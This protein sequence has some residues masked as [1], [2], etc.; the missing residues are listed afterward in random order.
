MR[1]VPRLLPLSTIAALAAI[2]SSSAHAAPSPTAAARGQIVKGLVHTR[3]AACGG[4]FAGASSGVCTH[5][6]DAA[7]SGRD[8]RK[9]RSTAELR[10]AAGLSAVAGPARST[11]GTVTAPMDGS[12]AIVCDGDGVAG[13]RV[14]ALYVVASDRADRYLSV[15]DALGQYTIRAD[16]VLN[17]SARKTGATR[18][19]RF[20]TDGDGAGGCVLNIRH[21]VVGPTQ[22][23]D[24]DATIAALKA[25]GYNRADRKYLIYADTNVYCGM[26]SFYS[27]SQ[28]GQAN[29][30][31]GTRPEYARVDNG[32]W[33]YGEAHELM[34]TLGAVQLD[35]PHTTTAGHCYDEYDRMCYDDGGGVR[36]SYICDSSQSGLFDCNGDDYFLAATPASGT[37]LSTHWNTADSAFLLG[38]DLGTAPPPI[39]GATTKT[40]S[41]SGS[42]KRSG[43][44]ATTR[45]VKAGATHAV[46]TGSTRKG[47]ASITVV[48]R[49]GA[50]QV[51]AQQS[52][53]SVDLQP[54]ITA[55]GAYTW[56]VSGAGGVS[57]TMTLSYQA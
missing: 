10:S 55:P 14:Q 20:V 32:C 28:P 13:K 27:D 57:W 16:A 40:E 29:V 34:H 1:F 51:V 35:A 18:H 22:D 53:T 48:V 56:T 17:T 50:G 46:A 12:G 26:G 39:T 7:P 33:N 49:D 23:D 42:F 47:G 30:A 52:G 43:S 36:M 5:G 31:N 24:W 15:A 4:M 11:T 2:A 6:P 19:F 37:Y 38:A 9:R 45:S 21:V 8:V 3:S 25:Q 41:L 54:A 44:S